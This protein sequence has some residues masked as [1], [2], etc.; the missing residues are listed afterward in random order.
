MLDICA[1]TM[2]PSNSIKK[3]SMLS[4][5]KS[6]WITSAEKVFKI[7]GAFKHKLF[8]KRTQH[9]PSKI[10]SMV[11]TITLVP[12]IIVTNNLFHLSLINLFMSKIVPSESP[13]TISEQLIEGLAP[14]EAS[15]EE[16][17]S[18]NLT[19]NNSKILMFGI[20]HLLL[21]NV[22]QYKKWT[23]QIVWDQIISEMGQ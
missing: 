3:L 1:S 21:K 17:W 12:S 11:W 19:I 4:N 20:L 18:T 9:N 10:C 6:S 15:K 14:I 13:I 23:K 8:R 7:G 2:I 5:N 22:N 16:V